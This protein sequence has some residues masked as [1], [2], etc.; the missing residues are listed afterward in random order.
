MTAR[1]IRPRFHVLNHSYG[2]R[3]PLSFFHRVKFRVSI[4]C[5]DL[6]YFFALM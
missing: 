4:A 3:V 5:G 1:G 2:M 6:N